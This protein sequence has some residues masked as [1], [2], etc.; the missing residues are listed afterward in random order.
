M[1]WFQEWLTTQTNTVYGVMKYL[2]C[3]SLCT[4]YN[5]MRIF[6]RFIEQRHGKKDEEYAVV[7]SRIT[8]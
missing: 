7:A 6:L 4:G 1:Q 2:P 5:P 3:L 8:V